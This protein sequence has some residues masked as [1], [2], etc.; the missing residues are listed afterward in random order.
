[1]QSPSL[2]E[3]GIDEKSWGTGESVTMHIFRSTPQIYR[4]RHVLGHRRLRGSQNRNDSSDLGVRRTSAKRPTGGRGSMIRFAAH[5][6]KIRFIA[7]SGMFPC[8]FGGR[9]TCLRSSSRNAVT[10]CPR[11]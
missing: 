4:G 10:I 5:C 3:S 8:F 9:V 7:H 1:M 11:V 2:A 6:V